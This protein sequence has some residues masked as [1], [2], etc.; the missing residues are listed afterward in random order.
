MATG[1]GP[2]MAKESPNKWALDP[3]KEISHFQRH[4]PLR[5]PLNSPQCHFSVQPPLLILT[6]YVSV[7]KN[8]GFS[9]KIC[10]QSWSSSFLEGASEIEAHRP[11]GINKNLTRW[12]WQR[13]LKTKRLAKI[14]LLPDGAWYT[15]W[16]VLWSQLRILI[17]EVPRCSCP[18]LGMAFTPKRSA[19]LRAVLLPW[20]KSHSLTALRIQGSSHVA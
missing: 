19:S 1:E 12:Q 3:S 9:Q 14:C 15:F 13:S 20:G 8:Q 17:L 7:A 16:C 10:F 18:P 5:V 6:A 2:H 11:T 4:P